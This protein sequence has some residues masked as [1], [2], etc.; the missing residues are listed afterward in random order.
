M[1]DYVYYNGELYH[2]SRRKHKYIAKVQI[3]SNKY[4]YFYSNEEYHAYLSGK[5]PTKKDTSAK[6]SSVSKFFNKFFTGVKTFLKKPR[7]Q[8]SNTLD[9][10]KKFVDEVIFGK[11]SNNKKMS[12][13][14]H[15]Y[16]AK[17]E[18]PNGKYRY[19]YD[20]D[21]YN[22]YLKRQEY[23]KN[24]PDFMKK[25]PKIS[26]DKSYT[27]KEDMAEIN[28]EYSPHDYERSHNC[29]NCTAA[30]ELRSRGYDVQAA[31]RGKD[32]D[33]IGAQKDY[34]NDMYENADTIWLDKDGNRDRVKGTLEKVG[35]KYKFQKDI[36]YDPDTVKKSMLKNS[37]KN[38]RGEIA[39]EWKNG[40]GHSMAYDIDETGKVRIRD[41]Q[42]NRTYDIEDIV[43]SVSRISITR[44][45]NLKLK[46]GV[47]KAVEGN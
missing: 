21:E 26:D 23:Q 4:R 5:N 41:C 37:G 8:I 29:A 36:S 11:T 16:I 46:K 3:S 43:G 24:E 40:G 2:A 6:K 35:L 10:G 22:R 31:D 19:F 38:T 27:A 15:K 32:D 18:L 9:K 28:E 47:L 30:Y 1:A 25:V 13:K 33:Y 45:D 42:T 20:M 34:M 17:V 14:K 39:V 12:E 44:T 7:K